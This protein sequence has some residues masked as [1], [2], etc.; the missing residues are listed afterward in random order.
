MKEGGL[1]AEELASFAH[2][3]GNVMQVIMGGVRLAT[4]QAGDD[5]EKARAQLE[6]VY[7]VARR[8]QDLV[9]QLKS[10]SHESRLSFRRVD[11]RSQIEELCDLVLS[12]ED[13]SIRLRA[14]IEKGVPK[15][16]CDPSKI[17]QALLNLVLNA[18]DAM[19]NGGVLSLSLRKSRDG[20]AIELRVT[21]SGRG[22]PVEL[23]RKIFEPAFTTKEEPAG[24]GM[25]LAIVKSVVA[26]HG[27]EILLDSQTDQGQTDQGQP[28]KGS[29]FCLR[30]PLKGAQ[31]KV[32]DSEE[33]KSSE[34]LL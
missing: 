23:H 30:F 22:I 17:W 10:C 7:R 26:A 27:G 4:R 32:K 13:R 28:G 25:G 20:K 33:V 1:T 15:L 29:C 12:W 34:N 14:K 2:E 9:E 11:L 8:A 16:S 21:D 5:P 31:R 24:H 19:P 6:R 3:F 18:R